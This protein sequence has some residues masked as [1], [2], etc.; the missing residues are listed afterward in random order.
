MIRIIHISDIHLEKPPISP[1]T[2]DL[3]DALVTNLNSVVDENTVLVITGDLIDKGGV[4]FKSDSTKPYDHFYDTVLYRILENYPI[5]EDKILFVPGNHDIERR[6]IDEFKK[7]GILSTLNK[8]YGDFNNSI[9]NNINQKDYLEQL[10]QFKLFEGQLFDKVD[11]YNFSYLHSTFSC[12]IAG[13]KVGFACLNSAWLCSGDDDYTQIALGKYHLERA[14]KDI[15]DCKIKIALLHHPIDFFRI[16]ERDHIAP[17]FYNCYDL[18]LTGHTHKVEGGYYQNL[19]GNVLIS[20]AQG[21]LAQDSKATNCFTGYSI[22]ELYPEDKYVLKFKKYLSDH[23][24]FVVN[25][26]IGNDEGEVTFSKPTVEECSLDNKVNYIIKNLKASHIDAI[27]SDL[28]IYNVDDSI[29]S[30]IDDIFVSPTISNLLENQFSEEGDE[31]VLKY[32]ID[33]ILK[34]GGNYVIYA[35][36]ESGKTIFLDKIVIEAINKFLTYRKIPVHMRFEDIGNRDILQ[37][38]R[39]FLS[40]NKAEF[41]EIYEKFHIVL[42]IDNISFPQ[43]DNGNSKDYHNIKKL[44]KFIKDYPKLQII[45]TANQIS[46][47]VLPTEYFEYNQ[48]FDFNIAFLHSLETSQ[49][50]N[51]ISKWFSDK[52]IDFHNRLEKLLSTFKDLGL[53]KTPLS[54]TMF[55]WIINKQ[56][57][58]PINNAVLVEIFI[59][60]LLEKANFSNAISSSFDY[61]NK[62][63]L[64]TKFAKFL[65]DNGDEFLSYSTSYES[66]LGFFREY[67]EK[68]YGEPKSILDNLIERRVLMATEDSQVRF[69]SAF[70]FHYFLAGNIDSDLKFKEYVLSNPLEFSNEIEFYTG[71]K[72][73]SEE[74]LDLLVTAVEVNFE[75]INLAIHS[76]PHKIDV[77]FETKKFL[78]DHIDLEKVKKKRT[79]KEVERT[80]D[81]RLKQIPEKLD[82]QPKQFDKK[83]SQKLDQLLKLS[84]IVLKNSEEIDDFDKRYKSY[85][86]ILRSSISFLVLYRQQMMDYFKEHK[87]KP[88][89]FPKNIDFKMFIRFLP[90]IHQ[91]VLFEWMGSI[92]MSPLLNEKINKDFSDNNISEYEKFLSVFLYSDING[93]NFRKH[94]DK[95]TKKATHNYLRDSIFF[96]VITYYFLR[97]NS[98]DLDDFYLKLAT[99][100]Q[101]RRN[102][103]DE[104]FKEHTKLKLRHEKHKKLLN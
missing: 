76:E 8:S 65:F 60:N 40:I 90:L 74:I 95:F 88:H 32:N 21:I 44:I 100:L 10:T 28:I 43:F 54:V 59:E 70:F 49:I 9:K 5:L 62:K 89:F 4:G 26:D 87:E 37:V 20:I 72:R 69:K 31:E 73:D 58:E 47:N 94:I 68:K 93:Q 30:N 57:K 101:M 67:L 16:E 50:K 48:Y 34:C 33:G 80:Y 1:N 25:T 55:L 78:S 64:L 53:P 46:R 22:V 77:F 18:I 11:N 52:T 63:R 29:P 84:A 3:M 98:Q 17:H 91:V 81:E 86:T 7:N 75:D 42:L 12:N 38:I 2:T 15:S 24:K 92:K 96:K 51:L 71:L 66:S 35:P 36:P 82:I 39:N 23:K 104:K 102:K 45:G 79:E 61:Y 13:Q 14:T 85:K 83:T 27:N 97:P 41:E 99:G 19:Y 6:K 103:I 56:E